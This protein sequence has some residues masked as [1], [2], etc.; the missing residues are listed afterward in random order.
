[1]KNISAKEEKGVNKWVIERK[2]E[3][4]VKV[5]SWF[6]CKKKEKLKKKTKWKKE[7]DL[8]GDSLFICLKKKKRSWYDERKDKWMKERS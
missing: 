3:N 7:V 4:W 6:D 1:M 5:E 8:T 2:K